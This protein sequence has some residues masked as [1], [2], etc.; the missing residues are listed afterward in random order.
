MVEDF[1]FDEEGVVVDLDGWDP[2]MRVG[3]EFISREFGDQLQF[4][5]QTLASFEARMSRGDLHVLLIDERDV[6]TAQDVDVACRGFLS[7]C[8]AHRSKSGIAR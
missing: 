3:Y 6:L 7:E 8:A 2:T 4:D 1:R 5:A